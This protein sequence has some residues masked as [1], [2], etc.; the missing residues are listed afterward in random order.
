MVTRR[1]ERTV[2]KIDTP[3]ERVEQI[4]PSL[5]TKAELQEAI[6]PLA[7]KAE[8]L[9]AVQTAAKETRRHFDRVSEA[10]RYEIQVLAEGQQALTERLDRSVDE[11]KRRPG[12]PR[13]PPDAPAVETPGLTI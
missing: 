11:I 9:A 12:D 4:L 10:T 5:A 2:Q 3:L 13:R 6:A 1:L 7:T 8:L